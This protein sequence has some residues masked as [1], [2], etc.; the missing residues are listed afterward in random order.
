MLISVE[1]GKNDTILLFCGSLLRSAPK[2]I[3]YLRLEEFK[4]ILGVQH[5][6]SYATLIQTNM[7]PHLERKY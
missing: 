4:D 7:L 1:L 6:Q 5:D 3:Y 2:D